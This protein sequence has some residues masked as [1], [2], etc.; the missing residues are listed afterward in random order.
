MNCYGTNGNTCPFSFTDKSE[1]VQ[2]YGCLPTP[3]EIIKLRVEHGKSWACHD[4]VSKP[5]VGALDY[6]KHHNQPY[7]VIDNV[8]VTE[9]TIQ[10]FI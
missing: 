7:K 3:Y 6:L 5:C 4:D 10:Y 9:E 1:Q 2:N 8:L